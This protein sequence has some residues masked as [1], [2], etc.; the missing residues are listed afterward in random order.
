MSHK[1]TAVV[2]YCHLANNMFQTATSSVHFR[3]SSVTCSARATSGHVLTIK[4]YLSSRIMN[5]QKSV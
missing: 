3:T 5:L 1:D 2:H 4:A